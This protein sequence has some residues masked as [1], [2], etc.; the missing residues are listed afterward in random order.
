TPA[1]PCPEQADHVIGESTLPRNHIG[2]NLFNCD[3]H[4]PHRWIEAQTTDV[5][6]A[7]A[8]SRRRCELGD[9]RGALEAF[10][11]VAASGQPDLRAAALFEAGSVAM[12]MGL[13]EEAR[14]AYEESILCAQP[15]HS[16]QAALSL[17]SLLWEK[18]ARDAAGAIRAWTTAK[19][20][21]DQAT[22][23]KASFNIGLAY[24]HAQNYR[25]AVSE[26]QHAMRLSDSGFQ[27]KIAIMLAE[28]HQS[29]DT[30][31]V[32]VDDYYYQALRVGDPHYSPMAAITL[33]SRI[34]SREGPSPEALKV[35]RLAFTSQNLEAQGEA[36]WQLGHMLEEREELDEAIKAYKTAIDTGHVD[37]APAGHC[38]LGLLHGTQ[39]RTNMGMRHLR[40]AY[41]SRHPEYRLEAAYWMGMFY[42]WDGAHGKQGK[43]QNA[44]IMLRQVV[45]SGHPK[46]GPRAS[47]ALSDILKN[48]EARD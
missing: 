8:D 36:A 5:D 32:I 45:N 37:W 23:A 27:A 15:G 41:D 16:A 6:V 31:A 18:E 7:M 10:R 13:L 12:Q 4:E 43:L 19:E 3:Q 29:M 25:A 48:P 11:G 26:L 28:V 2:S 30:E 35:T 33:G 1:Q 40:T 38:A 44:V 14:E 47:S 20:L 34:Y 21:G 24:H 22:Q 42:W 46:W 9:L 17:G 39:N